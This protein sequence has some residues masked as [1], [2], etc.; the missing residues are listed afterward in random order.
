MNTVF[1]FHCGIIDNHSDSSEYA[2]SHE[3]SRHFNR[4]SYRAGW[5]GLSQ[6]K[7]S[8]EITQEKGSPNYGSQHGIP[9][10]NKASI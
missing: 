3:I 6:E 9:Y 4:V 8:I 2:L 10:Y 1:L 7:I 5:L